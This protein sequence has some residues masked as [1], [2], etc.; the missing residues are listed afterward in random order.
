MDYKEKVSS[1]V[2]NGWWE[3]RLLLEIE[4][5]ERGGRVDVTSL[6]GESLF[7]VLFLQLIKGGGRYVRAGEGTA[8]EGTAGVVP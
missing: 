7:F 8:G 5:G 6:A 1:Q 2:R 4:R 3:K